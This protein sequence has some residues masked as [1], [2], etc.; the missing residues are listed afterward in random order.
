MSRFISKLFKNKDGETVIFQRPNFLLYIWIVALLLSRS[1]EN[2]GFR[3]GFHFVAG[4]ALFAWSYLEIT[5]GDSR[6]RRLLGLAVMVVVV[7]G[8]FKV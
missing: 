4:A 3:N 5:Q 8:F 7:Y 6:F 1:L 2:P